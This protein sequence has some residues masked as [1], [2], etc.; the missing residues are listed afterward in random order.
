MLACGGLMVLRVESVLTL[1]RPF[2]G[3]T[4][5]LEEEAL[6][7]MWKAQHGLP[8]YTDALAMPFSTSYFN[9]L[10]YAAYA[11]WG[12]LWS[13][14]RTVEDAWLPTIWRT[15]SLLF[16]LGAWLML[17]RLIS[18][19]LSTPNR[20]TVC[21]ALCAAGV[22]VFNPLFH[23]MSFSVRPDVGAM[24]GEVAGL[25]LLLRHTRRP[26]LAGVFLAGSAVALAWSFKQS[27]VFMLAGGCFFLFWHRQWKE[28]AAFVTPLVIAVVATVGLAGEWYYQN[29]VVLHA[30]ASQFDPVQ[31][32]RL[33]AAATA[34]APFML[35]GWLLVPFLLLRWQSLTAD[36][37]LV[38]MT[39]V[40]SLLLCLA[41]SSKIGAGDYYYLAP[42]VFA[43]V[44]VFAIMSWPHRLMGLDRLV[45]RLAICGGML[46][47]I[48]VALIFSGQLG[49]VNI[50]ADQDLAVRLR[51][52]LKDEQG[53]LLITGRP[54]NLPWL[55]PGRPAFVFSYLYDQYEKR[56]P[57]RLQ[58][59]G[60][61]Q[62]LRD[63]YFRLVVDVDNPPL[64][65]SRELAAA[66]TLS[67][68]GEG[69]R[70]YRLS[71]P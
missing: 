68:T 23:W 44:L 19:H 2:L 61:R 6:F 37:R 9:E 47:L 43:S 33:A 40:A 50:R 54:Y 14:G 34:K 39:V 67:E 56:Y 38:L 15:L 1:D 28:L 36:L 64:D 45:S 60:L 21:F 58:Q 55:H 52:R 4:S 10:F 20:K 25:A 18:G 31:G 59:S 26:S 3:Q 41:T 22:C 17:A 30:L 71:Q 35:M 51:Q 70:V 42:S 53:P 57:A 66:Y 16:C 24:F 5:G 63:R 13:A 7:S 46:Q 62:L 12:K 8:V 69:Y 32:G 49:R 27:Q 48:A 11:V 65:F 29:T